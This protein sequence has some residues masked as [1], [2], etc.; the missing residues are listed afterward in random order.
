MTYDARETSQD[1]GEP[2]ELFRFV[3]GGLVY[4]YTSADV[5]Q[6]RDGETYTPEPMHRSQLEL[7]GESLKGAIEITVPRTNPVAAPFVAYAPEPPITVTVIQQHRSESEE[8]VGTWEI[9]QATFDGAV[10]RF[11]CVPAD[12]VFRRR[13]PR[14]TYQGQCNWALYSPQCGINKDLFKTTG[15][16]TV[17]AG[18]TIQA[19]AFAA[20]P[21]GWF[22]NG[23]VQRATGERRWIVKHLGA[24]LTLLSPFVGLAVNEVVDA[25]AGCERTEVACDTKFGNLVNHLGFPRIP[26]RNPFGSGINQGTGTGLNALLTDVVEP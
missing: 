5:E 11:T 19:S 2:I 23:W 9:G 3:H 18:L 26:T 7:D 24:V 25:Y 14:N 4:T 8:L 6:V 20:Q 21:D 16:V 10:V 22:N 17:V 15:T 13:I 12:A 1:G